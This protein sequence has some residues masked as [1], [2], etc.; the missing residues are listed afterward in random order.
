MSAAPS[1]LHRLRRHLIYPWFGEISQM[2]LKLV[3]RVQKRL[4]QSVACVDES[5]RTKLVAISVL[6]SMD[7]D[8]LQFIGRRIY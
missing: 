7:E 1:T 8:A 3:A 5:G 2:I 6:T 4:Q